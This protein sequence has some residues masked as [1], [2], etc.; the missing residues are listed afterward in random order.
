ML[1]FRLNRIGFVDIANE[2]PA[3]GEHAQGYTDG[4]DFLEVIRMCGRNGFQYGCSSRYVRVDVTMAK[5]LQESS[6]IVGMPHSEG[7][8]R[9][10]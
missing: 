9:S 6:G 8:Q 2:I 10:T 5:Y 3:K 7:V 1:V 4:V